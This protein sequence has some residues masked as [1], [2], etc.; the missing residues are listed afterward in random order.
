MLL[1]F[2]ITDRTMAGKFEVMSM[3]LN[4]VRMYWKLCT[5][6]YTLQ[7][8]IASGY[9]LKQWKEQLQLKFVPQTFA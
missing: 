5:P 3:K 4:A 6:Q 2:I 7:S 9:K 1:T 8:F